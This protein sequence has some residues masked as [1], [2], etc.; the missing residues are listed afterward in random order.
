MTSTAP[1]SPTPLFSVLERAARWFIAQRPSA[2]DYVI[3]IGGFVVLWALALHFND[4]YYYYHDSAHY[5]AMSLWFSGMPRSEAFQVVYDWHLQMGYEPNTSEAGLFDWGLVKPRVILPLM[6]VP[7]VWIFGKTGLA[8]LTGLLTL[9]LLLALYWVLRRSFGR[10]PALAVVVL[11][12]SSQYLFAFFTG[13]L[14]ESLSALWGVASLVL[15]YRYQKSPHWVPIAGLVL[16]TALSAFTRQATLIVAGAFVVAW[17]LSLLIKQA[18]RR[19]LAPMLAVAA[20]SI[21]VQLLQSVLFPFS[22]SNQFESMTGADSVG[23]AILAVPRII[24]QILTGDFQKFI[25]EDPVIIVIIGLA[26]LSAILFWRRTE[27]HLLL[28]AILAIALYNITNGNPTQFRYALPGFVFYAMSIG[29]L[30]S[31]VQSSV[32]A[33]TDP[34]LVNQNSVS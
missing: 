31:H 26:L 14:T 19:W 6:A 17:A 4:Q 27:S 12:L 15:A 22:Q 8:V 5:V 32:G 34:G 7:F 20:T 9:L 33:S 25:S 1:K 21:G 24:R 2:I 11:V 10:L 18:R 29:L 16:V 28:G 13:M 3:I 30:F 23:G